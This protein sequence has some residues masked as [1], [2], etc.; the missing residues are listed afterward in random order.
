MPNAVSTVS[1]N[2]FCAFGIGVIAMTITKS[3]RTT[4]IRREIA[5]QHILLSQC[6]VG[7]ALDCNND[8]LLRLPHY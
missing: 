2:I 6:K 3:K 8:S 1:R 4:I 5:Y 7:I